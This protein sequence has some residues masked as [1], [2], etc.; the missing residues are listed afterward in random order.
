MAQQSG[1]F[2]ALRSDSGYDRKYNANDYSNNMA[3]IISNGVRRS[4]END[5]RVTAA[6]GM[7]ITVAV[8]RAWIK[9]RWYYNDAIFT[10]FT[11]PTAP[12]GDRSRIDRVVLRLDTS[13]QGRTIKLVYL[14]GTPSASPKAPELTR[15]TQVYDLA[16]ADIKVGA[17]IDAIT[18]TDITDQRPNKDLCG[19]ITAPVGYE[20]FFENLDAEFNDW[21]LGVRNTVAS[22]T[23]FK[24]YHQHI[25]VDSQTTFVEF[26]IPQYDPSGVDILQVFVNGLRQSAPEDYSASDRVINFTAEKIAG[27]EIDVFVYKSI[28]G[29][30]LGSVS[31]EITTIQNQLSTVKNIGEYLYIC[32]GVDDNVK[33]S[34]I[35]N[36]F[37]DAEGNE[38]AQLTLNVYGTF[39]ATA[40]FNGSGTSASRYRWFSFAPASGTSRKRVTIDFLNCSPITLTGTGT[41]HYICFYGETD[42]TI[43]NATIIAR[44]RA[45]TDGGSVEVFYNKRGGLSVER[46]RFDVSAY[47]GSFISRRGTFI[48]CKGTVTN[49]R[50]VSYCFIA[51]GG[52]LRVFGGTY[53]AYTGINGRDAAVFSDNLGGG[54]A[55]TIILAYGVNCPTV[56]KASHYQKYAANINFAKAAGVLSGTITTLPISISATALIKAENTVPT[57]YDYELF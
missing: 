48:D 5:L 49:S 28:D 19:W 30:G 25:V 26:N 18:Q 36:N 2:N 43:K 57:S 52:L 46:C 41:N 23:L 3:A 21:Y 56:A 33:I 37:L 34:E 54:V 13:T 40:P 44:Q 31:D 55:Q 20:D 47:L 6:G 39:G 9:G 50:D 12:A 8:G 51:A 1:F 32:N 24:E 42:I 22:T 27:T 35:V 45:S 17:G 38:S 14:T 7:A 4:G 53:A 11:I 29:K 10:D 15:D 16:L